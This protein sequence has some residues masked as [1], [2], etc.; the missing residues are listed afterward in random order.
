[1][2]ECLDAALLE[3]GADASLGLDRDELDV[4]G[5]LGPEALEAPFAPYREQ[6]CGHPAVREDCCR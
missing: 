3:G 2:A 5:L 4:L 6:Y 1:V